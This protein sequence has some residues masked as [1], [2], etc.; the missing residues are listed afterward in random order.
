[1]S[2]TATWRHGRSLQDRRR[3]RQGRRR[4]GHDRDPTVPQTRH[5]NA[6]RDQGP[7]RGQPRVVARRQPRAR[8]VVPRL[9]LSHI[10]SRVRRR[11]PRSSAMLICGSVRC[12]KHITR[13]VVVRGLTGKSKAVDGRP[14]GTAV[15]VCVKQWS[16]SKPASSRNNTARPCAAAGITGAACFVTG[17]HVVGAGQLLRRGALPDGGPADVIAVGQHVVRGGAIAAAEGRAA[18]PALVRG[19]AVVASPQTHVPAVRRA[20]LARGQVL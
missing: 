12:F 14:R 18:H 1:M 19:A 3:Q 15:A 13:T 8:Y 17:A 9:A 5:D 10:K 7:T 11:S 6:A 16:T 2:R 4:S 20:P